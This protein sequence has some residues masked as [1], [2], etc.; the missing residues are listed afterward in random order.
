MMMMEDTDCNATRINNSNAADAADDGFEDNYYNETT[1]EQRRRRRM[2]G[3]EE[4]EEEEEELDV[5]NRKMTNSHVM[6]NGE[7]YLRM[8]C[9]NAMQKME[10][11]NAIFIAE[12]LFAMSS[13]S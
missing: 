3:N 5:S 12:R 13:S 6:I 10:Y 2:N 4:E 1:D 8:L 11:E 7:S 9:S